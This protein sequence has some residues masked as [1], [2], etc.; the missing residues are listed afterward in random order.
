MECGT[1]HH[2][3]FVFQPK[4]VAECL[5]FRD[6]RKHPQLRFAVVV[7]LLPG[8][9]KNADFF[10]GQQVADILSL[11]ELAVDQADDLAVAD[12]RPTAVA[13]IERGVD[14]NPQPIDEIVDGAYSIRDTIPCVTESCSPPIG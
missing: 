10:G 6:L 5:V 11:G 8:L 14:L 13:G 4:F 3:A 7:P 2:P 1:H 9:E 12:G